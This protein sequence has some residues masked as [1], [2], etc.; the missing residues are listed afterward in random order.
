MDRPVPP[1]PMLPTLGEPPVG[2]GFSTEFKWDG[3]RFGCSVAASGVD[4]YTRGGAEAS[5]TFPELQGLRDALSGRRAVLDGEVVALDASGR[6]SFSRLQQR[7]P[8]RR[9]PRAEL[10]RSVPVRFFAFDLLALDDRDL[11]GLAYAQRRE[12]LEELGAAAASPVLVVPPSWTDVEPREMFTVAREQGLEGVVAKR[13][14]SVYVSGRSRSWVKSPV[15]L[16]CEL[17]IVGWSERTGPG[18]GGQIGS[19]LLA[20]REA[21]GPLVVVGEVATGFSTAERRRLYRLLA[22]SARPTA[23]AADAPEDGWHWA[24]PT[25]VGE[26]AYREYV[27]GRG[28][29]HGA[30]R[31]LRDGAVSMPAPS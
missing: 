16:T 31:G 8:M 28:L 11:T 25:Y 6:P 22:A 23:P 10:L 29:R 1:A 12:L 19:L 9:R 26:V 5:S 14:D 4:A 17:A 21:D 20:G 30:W 3:F 27:P 7:W 24:E 13:V 15:R 2:P 18:G